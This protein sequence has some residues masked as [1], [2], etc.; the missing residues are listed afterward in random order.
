MSIIFYNSTPVEKAT[1][2][3][4]AHYK[5]RTF[6]DTKEPKLIKWLQNTWQYQGKAITYK[7]LRES[8]LS[9]DLNQ[10]IIE[11]W[12]QD[13]SRFVA[14]HLLPTWQ[15]AF[16]E[17]EKNLI[18]RYP[19]Y[20]LDLTSKGVLEWSATNSARFVTNV[21][22]TQIEGLR[23]V[24]QRAATLENMSVSSL[25]RAIRP[26]VGLTYPQAMANLN[27]YQK[28]I[29]S[30]MKEKKAVEKS[31][32][33]SARQ[34]RYRA[35]MI[36]R[37]ELAFAYNQGE[38]IAVRQAQ[39]QGLMGK[40]IKRWATADD[41]RTCEICGG[42]D[43][44]EIEMDDGFDFPSKLK[45]EVIYRTPPAHP[46]CRCEVMY[47]EVEPPQ[48]QP[49]QTEQTTPQN[50]EEDTPG[51]YE[52]AFVPAKTIKEANEYAKNTLGIPYADYKGTSLEVANE[53]NRGLT[54]NFNRFPELRDNFN[55][56]GTIQ[57]R[58][59]LAKKIMYQPTMEK[60]KAVNP[61]YT[62][63]QLDSAVK[64]YV[65]K[66]YAPPVK[67]IT[68]AQSYRLKELQGVTISDKWQGERF[69][70]ALSEDVASKF[71]P[72]GADTIRSV[73]DH[74]I[75]HQLDNM[76]DL[77]DNVEITK[78]YRSMKP[79]EMT[80]AL[81]KYA[82]DNS[83]RSETG[84]FIAEAWS[85]YLNNPKPRPVAKKVGEIIEEEYAKWL[86]SKT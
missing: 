74:E 35:Q 42:L 64:K 75:G 2:L 59:K 18:A 41:E 66:K 78:L 73:L 14:E 8:I 85:E 17:A 57:N 11:D 32:R 86:K 13:Y 46:Q 65:A 43:G 10:E 5:L 54:D 48:Y 50:S 33:Y 79:E 84:E 82:W 27:Y 52:R 71:H 26:M 83:N 47:I 77:W 80:E 70:K 7:E 30:G 51:D 24:V 21:T 38:D 4:A 40:T 69:L 29:D 49:Q 56:V 37:T 9:G 76:L 22:S 55:F 62:E 67:S 20:Y 6:I 53:W 45:G 12:Q 16:K 44:K 31:I 58:N 3:S 36:A 28:L 34:H 23:A 25:A 15:E 61:G 81:S 39:E 19:T 60:F 63:K 68:Y 72:E 1:Q